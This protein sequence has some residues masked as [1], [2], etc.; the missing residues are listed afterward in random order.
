MVSSAESLRLG[1][2][3]AVP[4]DG[5]HAWA[6]LVLVVISGWVSVKSIM[7]MVATA[8]SFLMP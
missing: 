6:G 8:S 5:T 4:H 7:W 1:T 2:E 3:R